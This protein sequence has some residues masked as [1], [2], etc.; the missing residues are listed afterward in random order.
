MGVDRSS[1]DPGDGAD[2]VGEK[3]R[4]GST[5]HD[6]AIDDAAGVEH[7]GVIAVK[8]G[9]SLVQAQVHHPMQDPRCDLSCVDGTAT[10]TLAVEVIRIGADVARDDPDDAARHVS[11]ALDPGIHG[12]PHGCG[13]R[14]AGK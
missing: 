7:R 8:H 1:C 2:S 6:L 10:A 12:A 14:S 9:P 4:S 13:R 11:L 5:D 3:I